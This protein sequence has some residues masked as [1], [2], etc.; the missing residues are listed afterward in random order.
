MSAQPIPPGLDDTNTTVNANETFSAEISSQPVWR[1]PARVSRVVFLAIG[2]DFPINP[3]KWAI[4]NR[5]IIDDMKCHNGIEV[6][7]VGSELAG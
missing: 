2:L 6:A 3:S 5:I 1:L 4:V 7:L